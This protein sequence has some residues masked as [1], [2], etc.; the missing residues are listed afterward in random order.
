MMMQNQ[1]KSKLMGLTSGLMSMM[2]GKMGMMGGGGHGM[3]TLMTGG[4]MMGNPCCMM[5]GD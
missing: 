2:G 5:G 3:N 4:M 1:L